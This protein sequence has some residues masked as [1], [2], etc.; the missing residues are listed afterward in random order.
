MHY[1]YLLK[2]LKDTKLY[3]GR[4][5]D[6]RRRIDEHNSGK[7]KATRYRRPL[8]LVFYEAFRVKQDAVRRELYFKTSR[9]K[10]TLKI[11]LT[12]SLK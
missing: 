3:V 5:D 6:L 12:E 2:S 8:R 4:T 9:G 7:I 11:M 10:S 1:V